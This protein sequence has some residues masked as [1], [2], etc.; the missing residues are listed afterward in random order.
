VVD[1][2]PRLE[3]RG[4]ED[5]PLQADNDVEDHH[6]GVKGVP[7]E[8]AAGDDAERPDET[9]SGLDRDIPCHHGSCADG[10]SLHDA[11]VDP[12]KDYA[13]SSQDL[14]SLASSGLRS[15]QVN[16]VPRD[17][18]LQLRWEVHDL[19][20][21]GFRVG[22]LDDLERIL[23]HAQARKQAIVCH[24]HGPWSMFRDRTLYPRGL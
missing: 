5:G 22:V 3:G 20:Q 19:Y 16:T 10:P 21:G 14:R 6:D 9:R 15:N 18:L 2:D 13:S 8:V 4:K 12:Q 24:L 23:E 11:W 1:D 17:L 7:D